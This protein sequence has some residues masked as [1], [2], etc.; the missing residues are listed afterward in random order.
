MKLIFRVIGKLH[1][2]F[3]KDGVE[4]FTKRITNYFPAEWHIIPMPKNAGNL[5]EA[6][7]KKKEG[8]LLL[9]TFAKEDYVVLLDERGKQLT[10]EGFAQ[11]IQQRAN[12]STKNLVFIMA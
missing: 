4:L 8:E 6:E 11:F 7:L 1:E 12:E 5:S 10:S 9:Q 3:V 2:P